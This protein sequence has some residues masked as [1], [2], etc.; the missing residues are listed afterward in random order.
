MWDTTFND[1]CSS[2]IKNLRSVWALVTS[3]CYTLIFAAEPYQIGWF[4]KKSE[5]HLKS[6]ALLTIINNS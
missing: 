5:K 3:E 1:K 2:L 6:T 4:G